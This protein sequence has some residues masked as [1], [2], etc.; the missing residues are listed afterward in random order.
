MP[1]NIMIQMEIPIAQRQPT[2]KNPTK[3]PSMEQSQRQ[4]SMRKAQNNRDITVLLTAK[5]E[6]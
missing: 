4:A 6:P 5:A 3:K 2:S 1:S